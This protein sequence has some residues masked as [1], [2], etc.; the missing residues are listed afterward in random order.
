MNSVQN[1]VL[2]KTLGK[3]QTPVFNLKWIY[4]AAALLLLIFTANFLINTNSNKET[5]AK[6]QLTAQNEVVPQQNSAAQAFTSSGDAVAQNTP[7]MSDTND[8]DE[9]NLT[10][11][12]VS[13]LNGIKQ[14][15]GNTDLATVNKMR[16][17]SPTEAQIDNVLD[18]FSSSE[19]ASLS[20]NSEQDVYLD[21]YN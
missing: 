12:K 7:D 8:S 18:G 2:Q 1:N 5:A 20:N 19:I 10:S 11:Q 21:L 15:K 3:T 4:A 14:S 17:N 6:T 9:A 16:T 13:H